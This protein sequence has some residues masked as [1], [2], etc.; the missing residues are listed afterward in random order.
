MWRSS[1]NSLEVREEQVLRFPHYCHRDGTPTPGLTV[2]LQSL[3]RAEGL[4]GATE[5][6]P[7]GSTWFHQLSTWSML[8][9]T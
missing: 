8:G 4:L 2:V 3:S 5:V 1:G 9:R 7:G 6:W